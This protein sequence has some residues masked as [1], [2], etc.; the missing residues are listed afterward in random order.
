MGVES[1]R[2]DRL[3][4]SVPGLRRGEARWLG[5]EVAR[6]LSEELP[7]AARPQ[8][9]GALSVRAEAPEGTP[10]AEMVERIVATLL[11][12]LR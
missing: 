7:R 6:R 4:L 3:H 9:L 12:S 2:I 5:Q 8:H 11:A 1:V 10:V